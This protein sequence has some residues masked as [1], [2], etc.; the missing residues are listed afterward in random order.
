[1]SSIEQ[2]T[3]C[4]ALAV[5]LAGGATAVADALKISHQAVYLWVKTNKCPANRVLQLEQLCRG[6]VTRYQLRPD[7]YPMETMPLVTPERNQRRR[8]FA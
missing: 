1:M 7:I 4:T 5:L 2:K 3:N 6:Q 8:K